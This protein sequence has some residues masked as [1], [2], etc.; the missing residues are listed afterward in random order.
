MLFLWWIPFWLAEPVFA[1]LFG[2]TTAQGKHRL[3][4]A[5]LIVQTVVGLVGLLMAG[6]Q[7]AAVVRQ[8]SFRKTPGVV[9]R[10]II[11]GDI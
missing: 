7:I 4:I 8:V 3:L 5:I 2:V 1:A 11:H 9:W 10:I 6:W